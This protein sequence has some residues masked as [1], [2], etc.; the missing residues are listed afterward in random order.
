MNDNGNEFGP[1]EEKLGWLLAV[2]AAVGDLC[3]RLGDEMLAAE[4]AKAEGALAVLEGLMP[5]VGAW[6]TAKASVVA[7][8]SVE[9]QHEADT[10]EADTLTARRL[11]LRELLPDGRGR[12]V[13]MA[14]ALA[15]EL[16]ASQD[17]IRE[18]QTLGDHPDPWPFAMGRSLATELHNAASADPV[19]FGLPS[20]WDQ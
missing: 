20:P 10:I 7:Q 15:K 18:S 17:L 11:E 1:L 13:V 8:Q 4:V 14:R 16:A 9:T 12:I 3:F 6:S 5:A 19:A 2:K